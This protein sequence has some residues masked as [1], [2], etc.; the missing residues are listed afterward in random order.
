MNR[1]I[2]IVTALAALAGLALAAPLCWFLFWRAPKPELRLVYQVSGKR[3]PQQLRRAVEVVRK[4][5]EVFTRHA[6]VTEQPGGVLHLDLPGTTRPQLAA[7]KACLTRRGSFEIRPVDDGSALM[8]RVARLAATRQGLE[9]SQD[10][11]DGKDQG[12]VTYPRIASGELSQLKA[13]V[14]ALPPALK[15]PDD[16]ELLYGAELLAGPG[17]TIKYDLYYT[18]RRAGLTSAQLKDAE[19]I[20]DERFGQPEVNVTLTQQGARQFEQLS[21]ANVGRRLAIVLDGTVNSAPVVQERIS[22]GRLRITLGHAKD[23]A[24]LLQR[25]KILAAALRS[26]GGVLQLTLTREY[27]LPRP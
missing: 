11:Y 22:G 8:R 18:H 26:G 15:L 24:V 27:K 23:P 12:T 16:R 17:G 4:R 2:L 5:V 19:L 14:A 25:A 20:W 1:K 3:S 10:S 6:L 7:I 21:A 13:F 9:V